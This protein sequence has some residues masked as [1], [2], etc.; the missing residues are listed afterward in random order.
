MIFA[1]G[2]R[3]R[4]LFHSFLIEEKFSR[5]KACCCGGCCGYEL[6]STDDLAWGEFK[7]AFLQ[8]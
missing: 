8:D 6:V 3:L 7:E 2:S 4:L 5:L 1:T